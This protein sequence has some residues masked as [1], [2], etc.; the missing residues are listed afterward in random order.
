MEKEKEAKEKEEQ[1]SFGDVSVQLLSRVSGSKWRWSESTTLNSRR[2]DKIVNM[3]RDLLCVR[4]VCRECMRGCESVWRLVRM[5]WV[6]VR[7]LAPGS[8]GCCV[9]QKEWTC[10]QCHFESESC[11]DV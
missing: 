6:C 8:G 5:M 7:S 1:H 11:D 4:T 2:R 3:R 9:L 10:C